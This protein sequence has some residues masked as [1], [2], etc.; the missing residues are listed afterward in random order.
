M[1]PC[2]VHGALARMGVVRWSPHG[3]PSP[4]CRWIQVSKIVIRVAGNVGKLPQLLPSLYLLQLGKLFSNSIPLAQCMCAAP[5]I[6]VCPCTQKISYMAYTY[7]VLVNN[8]F[9]GNTFYTAG[10][11]ALPGSALI[12]SGD[13]NG[14]SSERGRPTDMLLQL[15][16]FL[17][18]QDI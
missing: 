16:F 18:L 11:A 8:E 17:R 7:T 12:P 4:T 9:D 10:G 5:R 14:L 6:T 2:I 1:M 13:Q 3:S 15:A